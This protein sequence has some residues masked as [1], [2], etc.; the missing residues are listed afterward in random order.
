MEK[1]IM[2]FALAAGLLL[3][4]GTA[5]RPAGTQQST[6]ANID[7]SDEDPFLGDFSADSAYAHIE[8]QVSFGPRIPGTEAHRLCRDYIVSELRRYGVDSILIQET[9]VTAF[10]GDKLPV[11]NIISGFNTNR[12]ARRRIL[13]AAHWDTRPWADHDPNP[14]NRTK[15]FDGANDGASGVAVLLEIARN[16]GKE[17]PAVGV[18]LLFVDAEDYGTN[19]NYVENDDT[20]CLG[21]QYWVENMIPYRSDN[22]PVYGILLDMVGGRDA[23]FHYEYFSFINAKTPT[24]KVWSEAQQLGFGDIFITEIGGSV[25]DDHRVITNAGI[26]TTDIIENANAQTSSFNPTWHTAADNLSNIDKRTLDAVGK[27]VL[28]VVYKEKALDQ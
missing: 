26:P 17:H 22:R 21:S 8:R 24:L 27:T 11:Y 23:K 20:W 12:Q 25:N 16:L 13:L 14:D 19:S 3:A 18:D 15:P 9:E 1:K 10:N 6:R 5:C 28:N 4:L 2:I 7:L